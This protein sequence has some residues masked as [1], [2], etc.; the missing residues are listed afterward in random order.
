[1][2][3]TQESSERSTGNGTAQPIGSQFTIGSN[4]TVVVDCQFECAEVG[5]TNAKIFNVR[6]IFRNDGGV[7]TA[8]GQTNT[9]GPVDLGTPF[10]ASVLIDY[11]GTTVTVKVTGVNARDFRWRCDRQV[12]SVSNV[13][14]DPLSYG[15]PI[16]WLDAS[17]LTP[18][19]VG[20]SKVQSINNRVPGGP[21]PL[22]LGTEQP[23]YSAME[24]D[25]NGPVWSIANAGNAQCIRLSGHGLTNGAFT[26]V[27][28]GDVGPNY[29]L[30]DPNGNSL[31][32]GGGGGGA[33]IEISSDGFGTTL[34]GGGPATDPNVIIMVFNGTGSNS[35]IYRSDHTATSGSAGTLSDLTGLELI[36][37]NAAPPTI[38]SGQGGRTRHFLIY[39]GVLSPAD[40]G[41]ILDG[42]G[43]ECGIAITP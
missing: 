11:S 3:L 21:T 9:L 33:E 23:D 7:I 39:N 22:I 31:I 26:V 15:T 36:I 41:D 6:R 8:L 24:A 2:A 17:D 32:A 14:F 30:G 28:V 34:L 42:F 43:A 29:L 35:K 27:F 25:Y 1:M 20:G 13:S 19:P 18:T 37:G 4:T 40:C 12:V 16:L 38:G 10:S 5:A